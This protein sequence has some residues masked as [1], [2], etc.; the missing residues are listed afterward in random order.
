MSQPTKIFG[1][2]NILIQQKMNFSGKLQM[3]SWMME[4]VC[5]LVKASGTIK[6]K[7]HI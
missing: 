4:I 5:L 1:V 6:F 7:Y 3:I 2:R